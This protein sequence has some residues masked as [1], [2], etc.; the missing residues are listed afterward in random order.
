MILEKENLLKK[1]NFFL[2][3]ISDSYRYSTVFHIINC[4][5]NVI[6]PSNIILYL[7][8]PILFFLK[9]RLQLIQSTEVHQI[10]ILRKLKR[11]FLWIYQ[12]S[13]ENALALVRFEIE[14]F[15]GTCQ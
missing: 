2:K 13:S 7:Y 6:E 10:L 8:F 11:F 5:F 14:H 4:H 15:S 1:G 9:N 12:I 3:S